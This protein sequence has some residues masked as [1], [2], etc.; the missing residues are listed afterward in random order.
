M[1][2]NLN[3]VICKLDSYMLRK[4]NF[5]LVTIAQDFCEVRVNFQSRAGGESNPAKLS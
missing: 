3:V 5:V 2:F 1:V 4:Q